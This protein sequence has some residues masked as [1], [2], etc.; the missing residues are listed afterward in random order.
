MVTKQA[1]NSNTQ[2]I[3]VGKHA[4]FEWRGTPG[5]VPEHSCNVWR[6]HGNTIHHT[7]DGRYNNL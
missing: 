6:A 7:S 3:T 2:A 4:S 5:T 1:Q